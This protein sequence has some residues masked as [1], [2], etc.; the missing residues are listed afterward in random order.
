MIRI[1]NGTLGTKKFPNPSPA[2]NNCDVDEWKYKFEI[3][4]KYW[5]GLFGV[6]RILFNID[7]CKIKKKDLWY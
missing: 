3:Y 2:L 1:S 4:Y 6:F 5:T 7:N